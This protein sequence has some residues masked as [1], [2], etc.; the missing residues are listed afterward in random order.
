MSAARQKL[1]RMLSPLAPRASPVA[2]GMFTGGQ[3]P[4]AC[5]HHVDRQ[6]RSG[7]LDR[8]PDPRED[9]ALFDVRGASVLQDRRIVVA[10]PARHRK[11]RDLLKK[12]SRFRSSRGERA[13]AWTVVSSEPGARGT[14]LCTGPA[15][16]GLDSKR[17]QGRFVHIVHSVHAPLLVS[18]P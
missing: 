18:T 11:R 17:V 13:P 16:S 15:R 6:T 7:P 4:R 1:I 14:A 8:R 5:P 12:I 2:D 9:H 10:R 3:V